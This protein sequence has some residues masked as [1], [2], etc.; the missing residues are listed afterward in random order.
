MW[1][2]IKPWIQ[3]GETASVLVHH[4]G[5]RLFVMGNIGLAPFLYH[6][7]G[8]TPVSKVQEA[9]AAGGPTRRFQ[10]SR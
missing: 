5:A 4:R 1:S 9:L 2:S 8:F 3:L 7:Q 6:P 10:Q